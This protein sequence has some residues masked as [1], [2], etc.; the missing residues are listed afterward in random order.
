MG[1]LSKKG[2][3]TRKW[4]PIIENLG[5]DES[6]KG[7]MSEYMEIHENS[8]IN[9]LPNPILEEGESNFPL[10]PIATRIAA[11]T[12]ASDLVS[13]QP[14]SFTSD[15]EIRLVKE[16]VLSENRDSVVDSLLKGGEIKIKIL[17]EDP[18]YIK[19][20]KN[21]PIG[22]LIYLDYTYGDITNDD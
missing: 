19:M 5:I 14:M 8:E 3:I 22:N 21:K 16:R 15:E 9:I 10:L 20:M 6:K 11:Q 17:E 1:E 7:W 18:E 2:D 13:V 12:V 4:Q